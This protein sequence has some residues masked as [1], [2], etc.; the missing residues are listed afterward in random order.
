VRPSSAGEYP[1]AGHAQHTQESGRSAPA[2]HGQR[3]HPRPGSAGSLKRPYGCC[4]GAAD[5]D[6][7]KKEGPNE[8]VRLHNA[9]ALTPENPRWLLRR[10]LTL[11]LALGEEHDRG[12]PAGR[13]KGAEVPD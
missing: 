10:T 12:A 1:D 9:C 4:R 8:K 13:R 2:V 5:I 7:R 3:T 11:A 6:E